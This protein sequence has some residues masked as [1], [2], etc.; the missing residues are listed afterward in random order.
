MHTVSYAAL[1]KDLASIMDRV[2]DDRSPVLVTRP[3]G[4]P[5]VLMSLEDFRSYEETLYLNTS[6]R[7]AERLASAVAQLR[8]KGSISR[9][10]D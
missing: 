1:R 6:P 4:R 3:S 2:N 9:E 10:I 8:T 7:N 5:V